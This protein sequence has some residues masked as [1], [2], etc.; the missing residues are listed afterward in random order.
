MSALALLRPNT[1]HVYYSDRPAPAGG[2]IPNSAIAD[3]EVVRESELL[4]SVGKLVPAVP[5]VSTATVLVLSDEVCFIQ[6]LAGKREDAEQHLMSLAPFTHV[7]IATVSVHDQQYLVAVN[8]DLYESVARVLAAQE[9]PVVLVVPWMALVQSGF[10]KGEI[11]MVTVKRAFDAAASLRNSAF[12][13]PSVHSDAPPP[14]PAVVAK[15]ASQH[16]WGWIAFGFASLAYAM[17][18]YWRFLSSG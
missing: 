10:T 12:P 18:I 3:M 15:R 2:S 13:L 7:A 5:G 6:L 16:R 9:H 14:P 4:A 8:Q 1:L 11:D 17:F